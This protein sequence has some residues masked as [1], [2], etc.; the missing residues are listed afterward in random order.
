MTM[1]SSRFDV[2]SCTKS[3]TGTAWGLLLED[4]RQE[5]LPNRQQVDLDSPAYNFIPQGHPLSDPRKEAITI[6]Q[7]LTMT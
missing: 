7:L 3:L 4:S 6:R 5:R 2:W 1:P